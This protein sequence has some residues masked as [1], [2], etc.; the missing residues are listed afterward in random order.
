[1]ATNNTGLTTRQRYI[2]SDDIQDPPLAFT[3]LFL[4]A[5]M[6]LVALVLYT[7]VDTNLW[8][9]FL[10]IAVISTFVGAALRCFYGR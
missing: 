6:Y 5:P 10:W 7:F 2:H 1:M 3:L 4:A 9:I 8:L